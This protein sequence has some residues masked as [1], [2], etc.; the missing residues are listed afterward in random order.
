M[1]E[2][3]AVC[4]NCIDG[5]VQLPAINW[6]KNN[7]AIDCVDM[8][9]EPGMDGFLADTNSSFDAINQKI[10]ISIDKNAASMIFVIGHHDCQ[11]NPVHESVHREHIASAVV[12]LKDCFSAI[13]IAGLWINDQWTVELCK[14][15][16]Q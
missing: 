5:R 14:N 3:R 7:N 16:N 10:Q 12:R 6:I 13:T 11:G 15:D 4:L 9:T 2:K 1:M 8:I